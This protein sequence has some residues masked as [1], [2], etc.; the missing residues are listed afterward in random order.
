MRRVRNAAARCAAAVVVACA[1]A[2][3]AATPP[4][5][6]VQPASGSAAA[7]AAAA[8]F[9][10]PGRDVHWF[11]R[12]AERRAAYAQ[13]YLLAWERVQAATQDPQ[14][15]WAVVLDADETVLDNS[16]FQEE[17]ARKGRARMTNEEFDGWALRAQAAGFPAAL[18]FLRRVRDRGGR[19][20]IVTN[21]RENT[22]EATRA[23]LRSVGAPFDAVLC[24][25]AGNGDKQPRF[26]AVASGTA[27]PGAGPLEVVLYVGDNIKD[28]PGQTQQ[29]VDPTLFGTRCIV[30]PNPMYGSWVPAAAK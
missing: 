20:A 7:A 2:A 4:E 9:G 24:A 27:F 23:N 29:R 19:I 28:C 15:R 17:M 30:L 12:S 10:D 11:R 3:C 13:A 14:R 22:C 21:R 1:F 6:A 16:A 26:D 5:R 8:S 18:E 25:P